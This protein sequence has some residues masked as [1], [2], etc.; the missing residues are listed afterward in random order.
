MPI[1]Q[2]SLVSTAQPNGGTSNILRMYD[3]DARE[4]MQSWFAPEGFNNEAKVAAIIADTDE[5]L[6]ENEYR[7][8]VGL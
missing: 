3:Q 2:H 7:T 5:Q 8:L 1:T 4:Y 6:A